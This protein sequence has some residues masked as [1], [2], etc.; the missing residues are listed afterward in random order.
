MIFSQQKNR[1][2]SDLYER[3]ALRSFLPEQGEK[4]IDVCGGYGRLTDEYLDRF[5]TSFLFDY[6][7]NLL[8]QA[9][10]KYGEHLQ[11]FQGSVYEMPFNSSEFDFLILIRAVH[12]LTDFSK[13]INETSRILKKGGSAIIEIANKRNFFEIVKWLFGRSLLHPFSF[14]TESIHKSGF[15]W[16]HPHFAEKI[17]REN[18]LCVKRILAVS[19]LGF[20]LPI[21]FLKNPLF[22]TFI[23]F[24]QCIFGWIRS[25]ASLYYL[26]EKR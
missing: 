23:H 26:L 21:K 18:G 20:I 22:I 17:F 15:F 3:L 9:K 8:E 24:F 4:I 1:L 14:K 7:P 13:A 12:H 19:K 6:A 11:V 16:Y 5:K 2:Y 25:S 10:S